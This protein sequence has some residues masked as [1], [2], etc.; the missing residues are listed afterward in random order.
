MQ[1]FKAIVGLSEDGCWKRWSC[2]S[3]LGESWL[4]FSNYWQFRKVVVAWKVVVEIEVG[5]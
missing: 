5:S 4:E 3:K 2:Y 1:G